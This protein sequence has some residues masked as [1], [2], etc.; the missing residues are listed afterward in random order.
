MSVSD[1][2]HPVMFRR[3]L[4]AC[5]VLLGS[6]ALGCGGPQGA[7][8]EEPP[9]APSEIPALLA[10]L[11]KEE[12]ARLS[13]YQWV[14]RKTNTVRIPVSRAVDLVLKEW[15]G[16]SREPAPTDVKVAVPVAV[17][18]EGLSAADKEKAL[19]DQAGAVLRAG[20]QL[21][22]VKA[23]VAC[24]STLDDAVKSGP[25]LKGLMGRTET[26]LDGVTKAESQ[27]VVD[28]PYIRESIMNSQAK[29]V[30]NFP[31]VMPAFTGQINDAELDA[32]VLYVKSLK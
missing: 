31:P 24:H 8:A 14:D 25:S 23:C 15:N 28:E 3:R 22:A 2:T 32:L 29:L 21:F 5:C 30:K 19:A 1:K 13:S 7:V 17:K 18:T 26:V 9:N 11:R 27:I 12:V 20:E 6:F 10:K 16:R 4:A